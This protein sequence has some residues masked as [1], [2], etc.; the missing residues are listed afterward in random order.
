VNI[1][2]SRSILYNP[3]GK[4]EIL[5][6]NQKNFFLIKPELKRHAFQSVG[7]NSKLKENEP[8]QGSTIEINQVM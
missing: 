3:Q 5:T 6:R 8:P 4:I 2:T 1:V 7:K